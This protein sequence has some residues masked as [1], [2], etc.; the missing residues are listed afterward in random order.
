MVQVLGG[1]LGI[2][3]L[4]R[5][6]LPRIDLPQIPLP[7][8]PAIPLPDV[9]NIPWPVIPLPAIDIPALPLL[10][11]IRELWS[12][13]NWLVPI[14]IAMVIAIN[15]VSKRRKRELAETARRQGRA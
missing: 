15:E 8:L 9:P 14:V 10:D 6:L 4:L 12:A 2:G 3:A 7:A 5:G 11:Q 1:V 13:V